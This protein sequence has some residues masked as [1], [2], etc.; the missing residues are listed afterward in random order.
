MKF[1]VM[2]DTHNRHRDLKIPDG[3]I[4]IHAGDATSGGQL[5]EVADFAAWF[6][7]QPHRIKILVA[8]NHDFA[9]Q[10]DYENAVDI[11]KNAGGIVYLQD[12]A[13]QIESDDGPIRIWGAPW[14]PWFHNW[15][16]NLRGAELKA[17]W[18]LIPR[19]TEVLITHGPPFEVLDETNRG[20]CVGCKYLRK[21][22]LE[23]KPKLHI[24]GH[25]HEGYGLASLGTTSVMNCSICDLSYKPVNRPLVFQ[26]NK[27]IIKMSKISD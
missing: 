4:L 15:A 9:F 5:S 13:Y 25:I 21:R 12:A 23:I 11:L 22:I 10:D 24:C 1:V 17:V 20:D 2:S 16:F 8:G 18:D 19:D 14:Q 3:D 6:A 26:Y 27:G 7:A